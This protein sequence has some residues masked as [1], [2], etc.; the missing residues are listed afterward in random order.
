MENPKVPIKFVLKHI[1]T[2]QFAAIGPESVVYNDMQKEVKMKHSVGFGFE[3]NDKVIAVS[4]E[5]AFLHNDSTFLIIEVSC[6]YAFRPESWESFRMQD[7]IVIPKRLAI[8]LAFLTVGTTR[9]VLHAKTE[10]SAYNGFVIPLMD[11][12]NY[13]KD[14]VVWEV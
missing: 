14:D 12:S 8:H 4:A 5:F 1:D 9:G 7:K 11:M 13:I 10:N 6:Y 3:D 2:K